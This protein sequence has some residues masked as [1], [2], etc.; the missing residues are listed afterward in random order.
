MVTSSGSVMSDK[1]HVK[2]PDMSLNKLIHLKQCFRIDKNTLDWIISK[3]LMTHPAAL[4][5]VEIDY[6]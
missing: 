1:T 6:T 4:E 3:L 5:C 2:L